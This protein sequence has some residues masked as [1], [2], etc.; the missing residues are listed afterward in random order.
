[1]LFHYMHK[2]HINLEYHKCLS[3][4]RNWDPPPLSHKRV[5]IPPEPKEGV[6]VRGWG[7]PNSD[8]W[9]K[10]LALC[11]LCDNMPSK[12]VGTFLFEYSKQKLTTIFCN[13][14]ILYNYTYVEVKDSK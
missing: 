8:D 3:P 11:L 1:M 5:C 12:N 4:R 10:S 7:S 9:R 2:V 13:C 6:R 14:Y